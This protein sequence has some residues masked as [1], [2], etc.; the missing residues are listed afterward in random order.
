MANQM[1][2]TMI[3]RTVCSLRDVKKQLDWYVLILSTCTFVYLISILLAQLEIPPCTPSLESSWLCETNDNSL[4]CLA[5]DSLAHSESGSS[6]SSGLVRVLVCTNTTYSTVD[7]SWDV[8]RLHW[9]RG[10]LIWSGLA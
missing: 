1:Q 5:A 10:L 4:G 3:S 6:T 9:K 7:V 2:S 8:C